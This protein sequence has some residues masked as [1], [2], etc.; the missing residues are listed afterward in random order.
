MVLADGAVYVRN[1]E[2]SF[3]A[4]AISNYSTNDGPQEFV[5]DA[6]TIQDWTQFFKWT[7]LIVSCIGLMIGYVIQGFLRVVLISAGG[8]FA[9]DSD[10][11][12]FHWGSFFK[13]SC[14][15]VTPVIVADAFLFSLG[16]SLPYQELFLLGGGT[17]FVYFIVKHL[18]KNL[19]GVRVDLTDVDEDDP[20]NTE[21]SDSDIDK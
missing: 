5:I 19:K 3:E 10:S 13:I 1:G 9:A 17:F 7:L 20:S 16:L 4:W 8:F 12:L 11:D 6:S 15:A 21:G 18:S 2:Q 14:Y